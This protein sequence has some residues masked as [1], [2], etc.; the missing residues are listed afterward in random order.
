MKKITFLFFLVI[1]ATKMH[2]QC[3]KPT[4]YTSTSSNNMGLPQVMS[5]C[6]YTTTD[7]LLLQDLTVGGDYVFTN[8]LG[9]VHK[10]IT[11]T[12]VNNEVIEHG[13]SPLT[14]TAI[15]TETVRVH[16]ADDDSCEGTASC[17]T[18]S[19]QALLTCLF[20]EN[21][22][23]FDL[24]TTSAIFTWEP[25]GSELTWE[26]IALPASSAAPTVNLTEGVIT[27]NDNPE[28][29]A[30]LLPAT[31]YKFYFRA[32]CSD[33]DKSPWISSEAFTTPCEEVTYFS[34]G[35][36]AGTTLPNCY[37]K[38]GA[39]GTLNVQSE[40]SAASLPNFVVMGNGSILSLPVVSNYAEATH[41][42]KFKLRAIY[43]L[44]GT[45]E[46]GYLYDSE[47]FAME[48]YNAN[49]LTVYD[50]YIFE[51]GTEAQTGNFAFRHTSGNNW[52]VIDD[53]IWEEIPSCS[54][55]TLL[56]IDSF[57]S[58]TASL[59]WTS[60]EASFEVAYGIAATTA[61]PS[62]LI[63]QAVEENTVALS[64]L[65]ASTAYKVWV[66]SV[67]GDNA[68]GAWI[69]PKV[70]TTTCAPVATF[71]ENFNASSSIPA[72]FKKVG[73]GGNAYIQS[74]ALNISSYEDGNAGNVMSYGMVSLPAV[75][76]AAAGTHRLKFTMKSAST[77]GGIIELGYMA[78]PE[79]PTSFTV[80]QSFTATSSTP[81]TIIYI[82]TAGAIT[83]EVLAFRHTG[84]PSYAILIDD[85]V[86]ETAPNCADV[87]AIQTSEVSSAGAKISW[88][89]GTETAWQ[90]AYGAVSV[91]NPNTLEPVEATEEPNKVLTGLD[92]ATTYKVWVRSNC[93]TE[94]FGAWIGPVQ[95]T[96]ACVA[97]T[98]FAENFDSNTT[99][100]NCWRLT[101]GFIQSNSSPAS[102]PNAIY[103]GSNNVLAM[104]AVTNFNAGTHRLKFKAKGAY[105]V[106]GTVQVGYLTS[107]DNTATFV[108]LQS[109]TPSSATVYDEFYAN[110]GTTLL[111]G[112]LAI[113]HDGVNY[114]AV[115]V[116]DVVWEALP[117][118]EDVGGLTNEIV[119]NNNATVSWTA[120]YSTAWEVV[121]TFA[122]DTS[123][124]GE[125]TAD[126]VE[127]TPS[128]TLEFL[129]PNTTYKYWVRA[130][131]DNEEYGAWIGP[132]VL[133]TTCDP[134]SDLPWQEDFEG[135]TQPNLAECWTKDNGD[136]A[137]T[138][139]TYPSAPN[140]GTQY[141]KVMSY[142]LI[143]DGYLWTPGFELQAGVAYDF[144]VFVK[145][146]GY[147]GWSVAMVYN[148]TPKSEGATQ[149][150]DV[151][152]VPAGTGTQP[153]NEM[154]RS[155]IPTVTGVY[156]FAVK[157]KEESTS[158][159]YHLAFDDFSLE[160]GTLGNPT[161]GANNFK[162]YPNP[163]KDI[164][165]VS[166]TENI[167]N[168]EVYNL[169]GQK[170]ATKSINATN[171]QL[172]MSSL[173]AGSYLVKVTAG[174]QVQTIK[175]IK[176]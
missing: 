79:N 87:S 141:V 165:N 158:Y 77:V 109:F 151:Y 76:N 98:E 104:P 62:D 19:V 24:T 93:G 134:T 117:T 102:A 73:A 21:L 26:V 45:V 121:Y 2:G 60:E 144:S 61:N 164:L 52:V 160:Q 172:D 175:V 137:V 159:P 128:F 171:G 10:Y 113:R 8:T 1:I 18:V 125:L 35:F 96:T 68:Y 43:G 57:T 120:L 166:Y 147:D 89:P 38:V 47:F 107:H 157:V 163:V 101:G 42:L 54:D 153:Y 88:T 55:I 65:E 97:V 130:V 63:P 13:Y 162:A 116:D 44:G 124:V 169:L 7:Y 4:Q 86:W 58:N 99:L 100:P 145:G 126:L 5:T 132:K 140:S 174:N 23:M 33:T 81:Q 50:E 131:C 85:I 40:S 118:C 92:P 115:S 80:V 67:C 37:T 64:N 136:W 103:L 154:R 135:A 32:V 148:N 14:V 176:Q 15:T 170:V 9:T 95:F 150:G 90:V 127:E 91:T 139:T 167:S 106:G 71:S 41:R 138:T 149:I 119:T 94:G 3:I 114:E 34:E 36:D 111:T 59:S 25:T 16:I 51:P 142:N 133:K 48:T 11:I 82:P 27:V 108:A 110:L 20:P 74:A 105:G 17:N 31:T 75:S 6:A 66:R 46:F 12:D 53:V 123:P 70:V 152:D 83:A 129:D 72:C 22:Q 78:N 28:Y 49:S 112:S 29:T 56:N 39:Q 173:A 122:E 84:N 146:D 168:V 161:F 69:G 155:F 30:T 143:G 156:F